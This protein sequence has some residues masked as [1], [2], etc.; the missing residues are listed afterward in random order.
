[1]RFVITYDISD[2]KRLHRV[3][4]RLERCALR[5]QKSVFLFQGD[6]TALAALL[7]EVARLM[8]LS[9]D[10]IQA[11]KMATD[12][13]ADGAAR[14]TPLNLTPP[15]VVLTDGRRWL[16]EQNPEQEPR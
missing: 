8:D 1:M 2:P 14:G 7:D 15:A 16:L 10:I 9:Q 12:E 6:Q 13:T 3:A 5:T 11:W 4:R